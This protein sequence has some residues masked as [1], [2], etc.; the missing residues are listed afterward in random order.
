MI[1][2]P[3]V[4]AKKVAHGYDRR[5]CW[6]HARAAKVP[7]GEWLITLQKNFM[8]DSE[9][10]WDVFGGLCMMRQDRGGAWSAPAPIPELQPWREEG[11]V[12]VVISDFTP[13]WHAA[14]GKVLGT[15][16]TCRYRD[17]ALLSDPRRRETVYAVYDPVTKRWS[18]P[19]VLEAPESRWFFSAGA[20][21]TQRYD[22]P[23]GDLLLPIYFGGTPDGT[24]GTLPRGSM[25]WRCR[26]DGEELSLLEM[27][28]RLTRRDGRGYGEPSLAQSEGVYWMT[29]R[30]D[31]RAYWSTSSDGLVF[32]EPQPWLFEDGE[33]LGS[34]GTQ[35]HWVTLGERLF[36]VYT[37]RGA[38]NESIVRYR[39]PLLMAEVDRE[40]GVLI[41][42]SEQIV[43]PNRGAQLG[44]FGVSAVSEREAVVCVSEWMQN[45]G[46]WNHEV[47]EGLQKRYP[48]ADLPALA[49]T[50]GCSGLCELGG[51]ENAVFMAT[52]R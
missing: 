37:R 46:A 20:G 35:Q 40:R 5:S 33:E 30:N 7:G 1:C 32:G 34:V 44:N 29:L 16:H 19:R 49:A 17:G 9:K 23:D 48:D 3:E 8:G 38:G 11:G 18:C 27:G 4:E 21:S 28:N 39:A 2:L 50:P 6:V 10:V 15:G 51:S 26:F 36:L 22:L 13:Q 45:A 31:E 52:V 43:I 25:V 47:W 41:R 42:E 24:G 12:E 14:T